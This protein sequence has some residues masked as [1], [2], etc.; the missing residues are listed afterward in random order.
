MAQYT[1]NL[2]PN[3]FLLGISFKLKRRERCGAFGKTVKGDGLLDGTSIGSLSK[4]L[5]VTAAAPGSARL[6]TRTVTAV[7]DELGCE[8]QRLIGG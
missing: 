4:P 3:A 6:S 5:M 2:D 1:P 8:Y 7:P